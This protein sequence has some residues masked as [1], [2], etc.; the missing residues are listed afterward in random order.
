L[1]PIK[2]GKIIVF[3][4]DKVSSARYQGTREIWVNDESGEIIRK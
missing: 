3:Q 4:E 1:K 2:R